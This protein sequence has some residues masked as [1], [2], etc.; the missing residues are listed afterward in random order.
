MDNTSSIFIQQSPNFQ[1]LSVCHYI[2]IFGLYFYNEDLI[3]LDKRNQSVPVLNTLFEYLNKSTNESEAKFYLLKKVLKGSDLYGG[4][5]NETLDMKYVDETYQY[6]IS[7]ALFS[8]YGNIN[9]Y[10]AK[11]IN[12]V[13]DINYSVF[14]G[15]V[16]QHLSENYTSREYCFNGIP[17]GN[18]GTNEIRL[19]NYSSINIPLGNYSSI[20]IPLGNYS[21]F[22]TPLGNYSSI[23]ILSRNYSS[24]NIPPANYNSKLNGLTI[25]KVFDNH[26]WPIF[27]QPEQDMS[28]MDL[29]YIYA[30]VGLKIIKSVS[31]TSPNLTFQEYILISREI[32]LQDFSNETYEM[33]LNLFSTPAL[34]FYAYNQKAKFQKIDV[35]NLTDKFWI[36][37]YEN[38]FTHI[39]FTMKQ[40]V[41][42]KIENSLHYKLE[43][44]MNTL[45]SRTIIA[46]NILR[47]Y[48][49]YENIGQVSPVYL[50][51]YKTCYHW[52]TKSILPEQ[53]YTNLLPDLEKEY[54]DQFS[55]IEEIYNE[56]ERNGIE[57]VLVDSKLVEEITLN[58]TVMFARIPDYQQGCNLC[59]PIPRKANND[60]YLMFAVEKEKSEFYALRQENN[61]LSLLTNR[62]NEQNFAKA[63]ANDSSLKME[64]AVFSRT[65]KYR[66][67]DYREFIARVAEIKTKQFL[68]NLKKYYYDETIGE[69]FLNFVKSLIPFY[70]CIESG[71]AGKMAESAFSCTMDVLSLIPFA[72]FA[73]KYTARLTNSFAVEIGNKYLITNTLARTGIT[74][75]PIITVLNQISQ[76]AGKTIA[77]EILT[78]SLLKDLTVAFLRTIDPG[79]EFIYHFSR[80]GFQTFRQL[81][82]NIITSFE[83]IHFVQNTLVFIKS[84]VK[85]LER[86]INLITDSMGLVPVVLAK[87]NSYEIVR[88][89]YPGGSHF[90]GPTCLKSFGNTAELRTI[91]GYSFPLPV[92]REKSGF[93]QQYNPKTGDK[94]G[95]LKM[96]SD[97]LQRVGNLINEMVINGRDVNIIRNYHVYHNTIKWNKPK[98][99]N[100]IEGSNLESLQNPLNTDENPVQ[101]QISEIQIT[102]R[103]NI[104]GIPLNFPQIGNVE[105]TGTLRGNIVDHNLLVSQSELPGTSRGV[106]T[107]SVLQTFD[108]PLVK[109]EFNKNLKSHTSSQSQPENPL[110]PKQQKSFMP[111]EIL[112]L[113]VPHRKRKLET[114]E[115]FSYYHKKFN[116][117]NFKRNEKVKN[118][119]TYLQNSKIDLKKT[120]EDFQEKIQNFDN[121][122]GI[123]E[124]FKNV[125]PDFYKTVIR[126]PTYTIYTDILIELKKNGLLNI[127]KEKEKL[128]LLQTVVNKLAIFQLDTGIPLKKQIKLWYT[129]TVIGQSIINSIRNLKGRTFFFNDITLLRNKP[130]GPLTTRSIVHHHLEIEVRYHL[131][132]DSS[133]GFVD[134]TNFHK[135]LKHNYITFSDTFFIVTDTFFTANN[136]VLN[137]QLKNCDMTKNT[138]RQLRERDI[139][140]LLKSQEIIGTM[141]MNKI[142]K[143][144]NFITENVLLHTIRTS[145]EFLSSY[146]LNINQHSISK[147]VP[148]YDMLAE[149]LK[150][151]SFLGK[152]SNW[153]IDNHRY[154]QDVLF[155]QNLD[156]IIDLSEARQ[157]IH[158]IYDNIHIQN[159]EEAFENYRKIENVESYLRFEDYYVLYSHIKNRL[160]LN[161]DGMRRLEAAI[162]RLGLRQ[163]DDEKFIMKTIKLYRFEFITKETSVKFFE[164]LKKNDNII[165]D[166]F[167]KFSLHR[168]IVEVNC[169]NEASKSLSIPILMEITIE[170]QAGVVDVSR[171]INENSFYAVTS[172]FEYILDDVRYKK[173]HNQNILVIKMHDNGSP[174]E[175][176]MVDM[177]KRLNELF[178]TETKFYSDIIRILD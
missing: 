96:N 36:E 144:A 88:Y 116:A 60:I 153:K 138:W 176:R 94:I 42:K 91:E 168:D 137:V 76:T 77:K 119:E 54:E 149:D 56:I 6:I 93:Y 2:T 37:A 65:L 40:I 73:A 98:E 44:E 49:D 23:N 34:F 19:G 126:E 87:R 51:I 20:N 134:L 8:H 140:Y 156:E 128:N 103:G 109:G 50:E 71:K 170:N 83:N 38:L 30:M 66:N 78:R 146:I 64:I 80:F 162:T 163:C 175:K 152:Y 132:T 75:L 131:T 100:Q 114:E 178:A 7:K 84:L 11:I 15:K 155:R 136:K 55:E 171:I 101:N 57:K 106:E 12:V 89:H 81:F 58:S 157:K 135:S 108:P 113:T 150:K 115:T 22:N 63:V 18:Y 4:G 95:K 25:Q 61:T 145:K 159:I 124:K 9:G 68:D 177:T 28:I 133:Y 125:N 35:F 120:N 141:R 27:P 24:N 13:D 122:P 1:F 5:E 139:Y 102:L 165:F 148:T 166:K 26:I 169:L 129:S 52:M 29:N 173:I 104:E 62:G 82:Q 10:L 69:K 164:V 112:D 32:D 118:Q 39:S 107:E 92:V 130:P 97:I 74:K 72:G 167:R 48:C 172:N 174:K 110:N 105:F 14:K 3:T 21:S 90:F 47:L 117:M 99:V 142:T 154:I 127:K 70:S 41:T 123:T 79:F 86:N 111:N 67:E 31:S 151:L 158:V 53:C 121:I 17:L 59:S 46:A 16:F 45:K 160:L 33:V 43:N 85:N 143:A 161:N 147:L